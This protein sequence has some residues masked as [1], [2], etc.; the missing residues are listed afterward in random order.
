MRG[1]W[2]RRLRSPVAAAIVAA[3]C[4]ISPAASAAATTP[5]ALDGSFG[6]GG[7]VTTGYGV[8]SAAAADV[9]AP[10]GSVVTAGQAHLSGGDQIIA[11]RYTPSG[12]P[13]PNFG[14][15]GMVTVDIGGAAGVD[16]GA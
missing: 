11:T 15:G 16:S 2:L 5:G 1:A 12:Q 13:D 10:D 9:V 14:H 6:S 4:G 8:W 3:I 7:Y